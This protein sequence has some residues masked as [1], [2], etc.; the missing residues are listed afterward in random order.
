MSNQA[1]R[2]ESARTGGPSPSPATFR[3]SVTGRRVT[4]SRKSIANMTRRWRLSLLGFAAMSGRPRKGAVRDHRRR[5]G[6][7]AQ[8]IDPDRRSAEDE[9][10]AAIEAGE[11]APD[12]RQ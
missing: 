8:R 2:P 5:R 11:E 10:G 1:N 9:G 3:F 4:G 12:A 7:D 6:L